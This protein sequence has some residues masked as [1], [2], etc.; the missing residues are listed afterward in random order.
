L[1]ANAL[2]RKPTL[3]TLE[4]AAGLPLAGLTAYQSVIT[5]GKLAA[6]ER[7]FINGGSSS[8]GIVAI[9][10]AKAVGAYVVSS[11]STKNIDFVKGLGADEVLDYTTSPLP[12]QLKTLYSGNQF[13]LIFD[14]IGT[15]SIYKACPAYLKEGKPFINVGAQTLEKGASAIPG[16][17]LAG[18]A[19]KI[20]GWLGGVSREFRSETLVVQKESLVALGELAEKGQVTGNIDSVFEFDDVQKAFERIMTSRA[21]GKVIVNIA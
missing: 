7:I 8:V 19:T 20:P 9:Q 3:L 16:M 2:I 12:A 10:I 18:L 11:C 1:Q 13:D 6:G 4:E 21:R 14:S 5:S 17:V 15:D